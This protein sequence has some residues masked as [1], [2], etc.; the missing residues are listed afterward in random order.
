[1]AAGEYVS[2]SSQWDT[3][4]ADLDR[5]KIE[6]KKMPDVELKELANI[7]RDRGLDEELAIQVAAQLTRNNALEAHARDEL[8]IN[9]ISQAQP[10]LAAA[11][12]FGSFIA[13]ALLPVTV[14]VLAPLNA[15]VL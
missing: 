1:M 11:S 3:E 14:A 7:Y 12:S 8:G 13:G 10:L 15:M 5:E 2:V 4:K 6:L 9:E